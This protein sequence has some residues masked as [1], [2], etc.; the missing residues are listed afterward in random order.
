[1]SIII[2]VRNE[3]KHG[4]ETYTIFV[5]GVALNCYLSR[6]HAED[7]K[8]KLIYAWNVEKIGQMPRKHSKVG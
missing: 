8:R 6:E 7:K 1:M 5:N 3:I 4:L 2:E